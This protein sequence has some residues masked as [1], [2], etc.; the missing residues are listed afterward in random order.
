LR[1]LGGARPAWLRGHVLGR[2]GHEWGTTSRPRFLSGHRRGIVPAPE[3]GI[4]RPLS[5]FDDPSSPARPL[6]LIGR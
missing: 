3:R 6:G 1:P 2:L 4:M 5:L